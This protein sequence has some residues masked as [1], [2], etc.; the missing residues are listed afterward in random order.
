MTSQEKREAILRAAMELIA[1]RGLHDTPMSLI[2]QRADA[3]AGTIYHHFADKDDLIHAIYRS[4]KIAFN[5]AL[6]AGN[7][8]ALPHQQ[9]FGQMWLN[10]YHFYLTHQTEVRFLDQY[11]NSPYYHPHTPTD[12]ERQAAEEYLPEL[13]RLY[14]D[15]SGQPVTKDLP[16]DVLYELTIGVAVR[17][18][19]RRTA[20]LPPLD[21]RTLERVAD[22]C[23]QAVIR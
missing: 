20:G 16:I 10:A 4:V 23:Y 9:A 21:D 22:M 7:L 2:A 8:S 6:G 12:T 13:A 5:R 17:L 14:L 3:S 19:K 1:E 15:D 18:A 11:E